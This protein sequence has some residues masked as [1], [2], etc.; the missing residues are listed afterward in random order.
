MPPD[1]DDML[2]VD[3]DFYCPSFLITKLTN[4]KSSSAVLSLTSFLTMQ[5]LR[6]VVKAVDKPPPSR[7]VIIEINYHENV[8]GDVKWHN[9]SK[10]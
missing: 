3:E 5:K 4:W 9:S 1:D 2:K 10:F 7:E 8:C 6:L